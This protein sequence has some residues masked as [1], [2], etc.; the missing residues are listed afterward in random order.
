MDAAIIAGDTAT[1]KKTLT[2]NSGNGYGAM[3]DRYGRELLDSAIKGHQEH[4]IKPNPENCRTEVVKVLLEKGAIPTKFHL[5]DAAEVACPE[6]V[7]ILI[8]KLS[9]SD[10]ISGAAEYVDYFPRHYVLHSQEK[11]SPMEG[12][13][14]SFVTL[15]KFAE[16]TCSSDKTSPACQLSQ[17]MKEQIS[18]I[19]AREDA[20][21]AASK[22]AASPDGIQN[23]ACDLQAEIDA[24]QTTI[25]REKQAA[26]ISGFVDKE[27]MYSA[28]QRILKMKE[29]MGELRSAYLAKSKRK[30]DLK[31]CPAS[32]E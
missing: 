14:K 30:L 2:E 31:K 27:K 1:L 15:K 16:T 22:F 7:E 23:S 3:N 19:I 18:K 20:E 26:A 10:V 5:I 24:A 32:E 29:S 9:Q 8:P 17:N 21:N 6:I 13:V 11:G 28:G 25:N 12:L 4:A